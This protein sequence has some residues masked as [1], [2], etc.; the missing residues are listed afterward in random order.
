MLFFPGTHIATNGISLSCIR[1]IAIDKFTRYD[2][3][4]TALDMHCVLNSADAAMPYGKTSPSI[5]T[6]TRDQKLN[7]LGEP[8]IFQA[9]TEDILRPRLRN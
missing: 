6:V 3:K 7:Q 2:L 8:A 5:L 1:A 9:S 4:M